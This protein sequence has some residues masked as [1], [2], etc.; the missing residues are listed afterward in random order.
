MEASA[1]LE[2]V[3]ENWSQ[4]PPSGFYWLPALLGGLWLVDPSLT[5]LPLYSHDLLRRT[6]VTGMR[7]RPPPG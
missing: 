7:A 4:A 3:R 2:V 5:S 1:G 6:P